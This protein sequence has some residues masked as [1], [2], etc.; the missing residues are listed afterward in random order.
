[1]DDLVLCSLTLFMNCRK[2]HLEGFLLFGPV[3]MRNKS[4]VTFSGKIL[5]GKARHYPWRKEEGL[6]LLNIHFSVVFKSYCSE[7]VHKLD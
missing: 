7:L 6:H 4:K 1:M 5:Q 2:R 3:D